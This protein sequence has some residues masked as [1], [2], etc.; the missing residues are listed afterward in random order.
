MNDHLLVIR[1]VK[2]LIGQQSAVHFLCEV[3][4]KQFSV[5]ERRRSECS[6]REAIDQSYLTLL[7]GWKCA[8]RTKKDD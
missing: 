5:S 3:K 2:G 1:E 8:H 6:E 4:T 7:S